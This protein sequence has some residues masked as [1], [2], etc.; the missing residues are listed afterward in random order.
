MNLNAFKNLTEK[1][2]KE[3]INSMIDYFIDEGVII[4]D[5]IS[6]KI[7]LTTDE[8]LNNQIENI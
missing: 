6:G 7:R 1:Q 4:E 3:K 8:E 5:P 2:T